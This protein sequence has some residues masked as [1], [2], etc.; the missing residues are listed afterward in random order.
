MYRAVSVSGGLRAGN[1]P[2]TDVRL[3]LSHGQLQR[4]RRGPLHCL[5]AGCGRAGGTLGAATTQPDVQFTAVDINRVALA[6][7]AN[8][9]RQLGLKN[10]RFQEVDL[11]T[12]ADS[13][14]ARGRL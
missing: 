9:A 3:L 1:P 2:G 5:D 12:L 14:C 10:I 4:V 8:R 7:A 11:T 6:E 13:G